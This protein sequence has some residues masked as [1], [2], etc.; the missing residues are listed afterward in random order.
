MD[1]LLFNARE[2]AEIVD[3]EWENLDENIEIG[4]FHNI[5]HYLKQND[6]FVVSSD[7]WPNKEAYG[8][9]EKK[10]PLA[11]KKGVSAILVRKDLKV[12][13]NIPVL[14]VENTYFAMKSLAKYASRKT[15]AKKVLISGSY[16]KTGFKLNLFNTLKDKL[17]VYTRHNS[18][19]YTASNYCGLA[20]IK[21]NTSL[22]LQEIPIASRDKMTRRVKLISPDISVIT[23]IG[24]EGIERFET[25]S[26]IIRYKLLIASALPKDGKLLIPYDDRYYKK[27]DKEAKKY[28]DIDILTYGS[29]SRCNAH[30][31]YKKYSDFGWDVIAKIENKIVA[32]RVP[33]IEEYAVSASLSVL[34]SAF[35]LD[36][37]IYDVTNEYYSCENFKTSGLLY[38]VKLDNKKF[39]LYD[40]SNRGGIEG[41]ESFFKTLSYVKLKNN[42][43]KILVTSEF[44]DYVD[45]EMENIDEQL[46]RKLI[47][48]S[49]I[50]ELFSVEKFSEH[51]DVLEDK[52]IWK[53]HSIDFQN[54]QDD[55]I[56]SISN[57]DL[58]C[59]KGI[60]ESN[61]P[62]FIE[63]IKKLDGI[64]L[65]LVKQTN[66]MLEKNKALRGLRSIESSDIE[67]FK[68]GVILDGRK[69]WINYFPFIYFW[70]LSS[71]RE[72]LIENIDGVINLFLLDKFHR[73]NPP[74]L[75]LYIPTLPLLKDEQKQALDRIYNYKGYKTANIVWVDRDDVLKLQ[76]IDSRIKFNYKDSEYLYEPKFYDTLAGSKFRNIRQQL[77]Q[78]SKNENTQTLPYEKKY[79]KECL[80]LYDIWL[81]NQKDKYDDVGDE[82]YTKNCLIHFDEF[83][84]DDLNGLVVLQNNKVKSFGFVGKINDTTL[85][86]FIGKSDHSLRGVQ[87][88]IR[89]KLLTNNRKYDFI[90]DGVGIGGGLDASKRMFR[91]TF[92]HKVYKARIEL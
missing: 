13:V 80:E 51:I 14:R 11:I 50:K 56:D 26:R 91:P 82:K 39:Y 52:N 29:S 31:L 67:D 16:G 24:H 15:K 63:Y 6:V 41:Y 10:I 55:V 4:E 78:M 36:L 84:N 87:S 89:Y 21:E 88:Y 71:S 59:I 8:N 34:L 40:Q 70:S 3:G 83:N 77:T 66:T 38:N 60:F 33:F 27:I 19:N 44:V 35:H 37:D 85:C 53:K 20:S 57:D 28:K 22:Y 61:L 45:G 76:E 81:E 18:A 73:S 54:I 7:N 2:I 92:R 75:Q 1:K 65:E 23:S 79:E 74:R 64:E 49:E 32:Y 9:T 43:K 86:F 46:F 42:G 25:I 17:N 62:M 48:E 30:T 90:N 5:F 72:I 68:K 58:V 69:G 12:E 47:K